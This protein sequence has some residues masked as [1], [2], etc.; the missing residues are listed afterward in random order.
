MMELEKKF[1]N[2]EEVEKEIDNLDAML[3]TLKGYLIEINEKTNINLYF[4]LKMDL[5][6]AIETIR[7]IKEQ[8]FKIL[9]KLVYL[10]KRK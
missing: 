8:L 7:T 3:G 5:E 2:V 4:T 1:E 9:G 10:E 6:R